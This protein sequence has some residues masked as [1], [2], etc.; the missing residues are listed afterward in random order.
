MTDRTFR[1]ELLTLAAL[2][3]SFAAAAVSYVRYL[4]AADI[5]LQ[6][7]MS[8]ARAEAQ[9]RLI[10]KVVNVSALMGNTVG[11][12][13]GARTH[14]MVV[15]IVD[16]DRC[17]GC[18]DS[19]AE[20]ARLETHPDYSFTLLLSGS[21]SAAVEARLRI[22]K[23]TQVQWIPRARAIQVLGT[24]LANTKLLLDSADV[25]LLVDTRGSGQECGWS[26]DAQVGAIWGT[27]PSTAIRGEPPVV[28]ASA[29]PP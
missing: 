13:S 25:A 14:G 16:L 3:M 29:A 22:L 18:F 28:A 8:S 20:W 26:F 7:R 10:G 6:T 24:T 2:A 9:D 11:S 21:R 12:R 5:V 17:S 27:T 1:R 4:S 15:W 19:V 23:R